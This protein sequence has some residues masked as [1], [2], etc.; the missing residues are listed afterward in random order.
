MINLI[1]PYFSGDPYP[2]STYFPLPHYITSK[3]NSLFLKSKAYSSFDLTSPNRVVIKVASTSM[4]GVILNGKTPLDLIQEYSSF[5]GRMRKLPDWVLEGAVLGIQGG[6]TVVD[7]ILGEALSQGAK[8]SAVW[9]QDWCG[10]KTQS[11]YGNLQ[12]RVWWN[13]VQDKCNQPLRPAK[14]ID[15]EFKERVGFREKWISE[16]SSHFGFFVFVLVF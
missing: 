5:S 14:K 4:V 15:F 7:K 9:L 13:W 6:K 16:Y 12:K 1:Q 11:L 10:T 8:V 3:F 2:L